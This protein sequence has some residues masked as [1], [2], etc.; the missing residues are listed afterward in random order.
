MSSRYC[1]FLWFLAKG[2]H[3]YNCL[4]GVFDN[5]LKSVP[6]RGWSFLQYINTNA[7]MWIQS[8]LLS[9]HILTSFQITSSRVLN[10]QRSLDHIKSSHSSDFL[11]FS[12]LFLNVGLLREEEGAEPEPAP[13]LSPHST[14]GWVS[15]CHG[16]KYALTT[17]PFVFLF[18]FPDIPTDTSQ[19]PQT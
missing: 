6:N 15:Y 18:W 17:A 8:F 12:T 19:A 13:L 11:S 10:K 3:L 7:K 16:F 2:R 1:I 4:F 9:D 14:S 5:D